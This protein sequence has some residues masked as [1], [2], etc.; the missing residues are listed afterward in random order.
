MILA[1][2]SGS[3]QGRVF[4]YWASDDVT[5]ERSHP[6]SLFY[7]LTEGWSARKHKKHEEKKHLLVRIKCSILIIWR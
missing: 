3:R 4:L 7:V 2:T 1:G 5:S 6:Y